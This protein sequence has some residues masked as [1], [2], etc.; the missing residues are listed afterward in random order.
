MKTQI[1]NINNK[2]GLFF[3]LTHW[4]GGGTEKVFINIA[5][6]FATNKDYDIFLF[7]IKKNE[8]DSKFEI[9]YNVTEIKRIKN[10]KKIQKQYKKLLVIN[11]SGDWLSSI[12]VRLCS[13]NYISWVHINPSIMQTA[14][15]WLINKR[16]LIRSQK[17]VCVCKE[18]KEI[19]EK[20]YHFPSKKITVI[21]NSIDFKEI[22]QKSKELLPIRD[23]NYFIMVA[24]FFL[25]QKDFFTL[26]DAYS[27]LPV[28]IK[29]CHK[30]VLLGNGPDSEKIKQY[31][32]EKQLNDFVIIPG[33]DSNPYKWIKNSC[34]SILSS[35]YEGF[36]MTIIE[37]MALKIPLIITDY[38]T[39]A[40]EIFENGKNCFMVKVGN[41][42]DMSKAMEKIITDKTLI[43]KMLEN[44]SEFIKQFN[45]KEFYKKLLS[46]FEKGEIQ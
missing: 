25:A 41:S 19:L 8:K 42:F 7:I 44:S 26:I 20:K 28:E 29:N 30:L 3:I 16:N 27:M 38:H 17:I 36:S 12:Y 45:S 33:F 5:K 15:T 14:R 10:F 6:C 1:N 11:F 2:N 22:E 24:R 21:Y 43:S 35:Y 34:C 37:S 9:P 4:I 39:G 23:K 40:R 13:K 18:Q 31:I 46:L 32:L